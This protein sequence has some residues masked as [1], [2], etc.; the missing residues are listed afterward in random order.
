M[1]N[2]IESLEHELAEL[3][4]EVSHV[5]EDIGLTME[6]NALQRKSYPKP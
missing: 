4:Q 1:E 3:Q 6:R 2:K 5:G